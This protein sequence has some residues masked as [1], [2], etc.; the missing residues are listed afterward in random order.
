[1]NDK[2]DSHDD[3]FKR[4][5]GKVEAMD[6]KLDRFIESIRERLHNGDLRFERIEM[7]LDQLAKTLVHDNDVRFTQLEMRLAQCEKDLEERSSGRS[8]VKQ[9]LVS[10]AIDI[11][12]LGIIGIGSA[13]VWAFA[14]GYG[15]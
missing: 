7:H 6:E 11:L 8:D 12:K 14:N 1:M 4:L 9:K 3:C 5:Y 10:S 13:A 15:G 2:C